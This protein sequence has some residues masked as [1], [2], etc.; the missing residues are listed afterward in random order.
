V[1]ADG[2]GCRK[3]SQL[4][5]NSQRPLRHALLGSAMSAKGSE[6]TDLALQSGDYGTI[7]VSVG[8]LPFQSVGFGQVRIL[9]SRPHG[10]FC[11]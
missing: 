5:R 9:E 1:P 6:V 3:N 10:P 7:G 11:I 8:D 2:E 4:F